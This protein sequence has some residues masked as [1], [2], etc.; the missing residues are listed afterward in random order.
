MGGIPNRI[1]TVREAAGRCRYYTPA[2]AFKT[3]FRQGRPWLLWHLRCGQAHMG[4]NC[5]EGGLSFVALAAFLR[6][7]LRS[8]LPSFL[9]LLPWLRGAPACWE[10]RGNVPTGSRF[11]FSLC[12]GIRLGMRERERERCGTCVF[13]VMESARTLGHPCHTLFQHSRTVPYRTSIV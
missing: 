7:F 9:P 5:G 2:P 11:F 10:M 6:S 8:F 12:F 4:G 13:V 1:N 3:T